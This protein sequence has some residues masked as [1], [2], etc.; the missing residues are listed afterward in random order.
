MITISESRSIDDGDC[1]QSAW[2]GLKAFAE[3]EEI[4]YKY[5]RAG[6]GYRYGKTQTDR[7]SRRCRSIGDRL[8]GNAI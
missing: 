6:E 1:V 3:E 5:Y 4:T 2:E 8:R 7:Q